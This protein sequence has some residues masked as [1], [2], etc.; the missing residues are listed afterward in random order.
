MHRRLFLT[1]LALLPVLGHPLRAGEVFTE[2]GLALRGYDPVA[3]FAGAAPR[4][5]AAE[6]AHHWQGAE[7]RFASAAH[8][9]AFVAGPK[10]HAPHYGGYCAWAVAQGYKAPIDPA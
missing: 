4:Q 1:S 9:D 2:A 3:C 7:W 6:F 5:G 10:R 8:R